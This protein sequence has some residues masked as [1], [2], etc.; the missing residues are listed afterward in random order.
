MEQT[1]PCTEDIAAP[2]EVLSTL[3]ELMRSSKGAE[4]LKAA[5]QLAKFHNLFTPK[6]EGGISADAIAAVE[7]AVAAIHAEDQHRPG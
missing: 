6:E 4:R 7:E 3:T 2:R 5:E 1:S